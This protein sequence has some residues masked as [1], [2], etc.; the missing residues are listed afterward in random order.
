MGY[1]LCVALLVNLLVILA[2]LSV[3]V[4]SR[5]S[6]GEAFLIVTAEEEATEEAGAKPASGDPAEA[7]EPS[8]DVGSTANPLVVEGLLSAAVFSPPSKGTRFEVAPMEEAMSMTGLSP[9]F[10]QA[11][12]SAVETARVDKIKE[13]VGS[14]GRRD[15]FNTGQGSTRGISEE[16]LKKLFGA[17]RMD[18]GS[19]V[20]VF[21]DVSGSM[22]SISKDVKEYME[23]NFWRSMTRDVPGCSLKS[24]SDAFMK[25]LGA[26]TQ[27]DLRTDYYFVCDLRDGEGPA[28]IDEIQRLLTTSEFPRRLHVISFGKMVG[29]LLREMLCETDGSFTMGPMF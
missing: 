4:T 25:L 24:P 27:R 3:A 15:H 29:P 12:F 5:E 7:A 18:D 17:D 23:S 10:S 13:F 21:L 16:G 28:G 26:E 20:V 11:D 22:H 2:A 14:D 19:E 8:L 1:A 6:A 9:S